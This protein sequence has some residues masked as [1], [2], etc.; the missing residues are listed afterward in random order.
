MLVSEPQY[1]E[2][3]CLAADTRVAIIRVAALD[4]SQVRRTSNASK[5]PAQEAGKATSAFVCASLAKVCCSLIRK[6]ALVARQVAATALAI[7]R[8]IRSLSNR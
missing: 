1:A 8:A 7:V 2:S 5:G 3:H 4:S 6:L